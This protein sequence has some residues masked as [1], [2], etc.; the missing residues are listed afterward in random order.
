MSRRTWAPTPPGNGAR[1]EGRAV[2]QAP[3]HPGDAIVPGPAKALHRLEGDQ[4]K[5]PVVDAG[6]LCY[7]R[8]YVVVLG[9]DQHVQ[10]VGRCHPIL[11]VLRP[12]LR[13]GWRLHEGGFGDVV[14]HQVPRLVVGREAANQR[15]PVA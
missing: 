1:E 2:S 12:G 7:R 6:L 8:L 14:H 5:D 10:L 13:S 9:R 11:V 15:L 4:R 3:V